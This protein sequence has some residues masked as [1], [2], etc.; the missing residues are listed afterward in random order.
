MRLI[1]VIEEIEP[2]K[3]ID[4]D[5]ETDSQYKFSQDSI[6]LLAIRK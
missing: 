5:L 1:I 2:I 6:D 4:V 3:L